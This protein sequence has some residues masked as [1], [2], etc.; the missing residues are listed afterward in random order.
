[1]PSSV[2]PTPSPIPTSAEAADVGY[3]P[4]PSAYDELLDADGGLRDHWSRFAQALSTLGPAE[5]SRRWDAAQRQLR[6]NG[7]TYNVYDDSRGVDR[8]WQLDP[9]PLLVASS[10]WRAIER[11]LAQRAYLLN[12][13]LDDIYNQRSLVRQRILPAELVFRNPGFLRPCHGTIVR[14]GRWLHLY[15][16]DL[17]RDPKGN[18]WVLGDRTQAPSGMG[19][20]LENRI[21]LARV[22]PSL[23]RDC[24]VERL[25]AFFRKLLDQLQRLSPR[26]SERP[27]AVVLTPGPYNETYFEH[28]YLA[29]YL[30]LSLVEGGDLTVRNNVV[31]LK[32][33]SGLARVD[34]IL[35]RTD[36]S[37]CDPLALRADSSLGV[38]GL[39]SAVRAGNVVAFNALGS[40]AVEAPALLAY[41]PQVCRHLLGEEL[42]LPSAPATWCAAEGALDYVADRF[43]QLVFKPAFPRP[44]A[45]EPVF[46][47]VMSQADRQELLGRVRARPHEWLAQE[48]IPLSSAPIWNGDGLEPRE[49]ALRCYAVGDGPGY[50]VMPGGLARVARAGGGDAVVSM[51]RGA[52]S[53]DT[54]VLA[55]GPTS[56]LSLLGRREERV[57]L[58]RSGNDLPSRVA[59]NLFWLGR[60]MERAEGSARLLRRILSRLL[61]DTHSAEPSVLRAMFSALSSQY[62]LPEPLVWRVSMDVAAVE[63]DVIDFLRSGAYGTGLLPSLAGTHRTAQVVRDRISRDTWHVLNQLGRQRDALLYANAL[64][65]GDA[66]EALDGLILLFGAFAVLQNENLSRTFGFMFTDMGRRLERAQSTSTLLSTMLS[67]VHP[68]EPSVLS[69]LLESLDNGITYRRRYQDMIQAAPVLDLILIDESNPRSIA[70]QLAR[71][72]EHVQALPHSVADP[73]RT[74]EERVALAALTSVRLA[75]V[76]RLCEVSNQAERPLLRTHLRELASYL[77]A[78]SDAITQSYLV[79]AV[80]RRAFGSEG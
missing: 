6:E 75:D 28:A 41:L 56:S 3:V 19:Y 68:D 74:R 50:Q 16:A 76:E 17:A 61:D 62:E 73:L 35:R 30:G 42:I 15:A 43:S 45:P 55:E 9:V 59:D 47:G 25:A 33:L 71:L 54:W 7:V 46:G 78:L 11:G 48:R 79:H 12:L 22:F 69:E 10:E 18:F 32:T 37:F 72:H 27:H 13:I 21:V 26:R 1:M 24:R 66:L 64:S 4:K 39:V 53:K 31:F 38:A 70:F 23:Y 51:Q 77:P 14:G 29:R 34:V 5:L 65:A 80:P 8:P 2:L 40:G 52:G 44:G 57:I 20:A 49:I 36:D 63:R 60:Y 58:S 67:V